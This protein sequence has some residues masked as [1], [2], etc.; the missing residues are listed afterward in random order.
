[1]VVG[2]GLAQ[3][4]A[5]ASRL[6]PTEGGSAMKTWQTLWQ[7]RDGA[8]LEAPTGA[9][10]PDAG[11][12]GEAEAL[13]LPHCGWYESSWD[14]QRGLSVTELRGTIRRR[15]ASAAAGKP[16]ALQRAGAV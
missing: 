14:L 16:L 2:D 9:G 12:R 3:D 11:P 7:R 4:A 15:P 1:M 13:A 8:A 10:R 6:G 5:M